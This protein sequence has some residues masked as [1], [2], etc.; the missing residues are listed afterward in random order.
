[1]M[2]DR[3]GMELVKEERGWRVKEEGRVNV[4]RE[5]GED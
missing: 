5:G 4:G 2:D 3:N 1:M